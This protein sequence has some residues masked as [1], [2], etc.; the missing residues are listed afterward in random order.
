MPVRAATF[1]TYINAQEDPGLE[2]AFKRQATIATSSY[3][4][5]TRAAEQATRATANLLGG[6]GTTGA[7]AATTALTQR[8]AATRTMVTAAA[9]AERATTRLATAT[10]RQAS[11]TTT[12]ANR[13]RG[14]AASLTTTSTALNVVSGR[15]DPVSSRISTLARAVT[16]LTGLQ[17]GLAAF[18]ATVF[19][20]GR[21][22]STYANL[23]ARVR[24]FFDTQK[25][26]N[27]AMND[28]IGI[29]QRS[30]SALEPV[31]DVYTRLTTV[32]Q[33]I[34]LTRRSIGQ[35]TELATK[36]TAVGGG[37]S[38]ARDAALTQFGQAL[39]GDFKS[40]GQEINSLKEQAPVLFQAILKGY[41]DA[42]GT[43]GVSLG[44]FKQLAEAGKLS[45]EQ[46]LDALRRSASYIDQMAARVPNTLSKAGT[47]FSN[48]LT[49][50]V[51]RIDQ[52]IGFTSTLADGLTLVAQNLRVIIAL[53]GGA[54]T[55]F[56][57]IKLGGLV[58][59]GATA[60]QSFLA[61]RANAVA[62]AETR[63]VSAAA[64][65]AQHQREIA[66]LAAEQVQITEAIALERQRQ[67]LA[68]TDIRRA[69]F[70][71]VPGQVGPSRQQIA[72]E[73]ELGS[74]LKESAALRQRAT[75]ITEA[76]VA[77]NARA[78]AST[79][80]LARASSFAGKQ[81]GLLRGAAGGL[82]S[83]LG[84]PWGIAFALAATAVYLLA[85]AESAA[86]IATRKH[87]DAQ[88]SF[89]NVIDR[90]TGKIYDQVGALQRLAVQQKVTDSGRAS[91]AQFNSN[92]TTIG[93]TVARAANLSN[94]Q[95]NDRT[96]E[97]RRVAAAL[98]AFQRGEK[99]S[100]PALQGVLADQGVRRAVPGLAGATQDLGGLFDNL[101]KNIDDV[102]Q[103]AASRRV[104]QGRARDG[105][106]NRAFGEPVKTTGN[107]TKARSKSQ[108]D[109]DA[110]A[111]AA[112]T[113]VQRARAALAQT[114]ANGKNAGEDDAAY[115]H[116]LAAAYQAVTSAVSSQAAARKSASEG[117]T[118][119][120]KAA[121]DAV[122]DAKDEAL[123][124]RDAASEALL[125]SNP[126]TNSQAFLDARIKIL[127]TY[128]DE[129]NKIDASAAASHSASSQ[130]LADL[131]REEKAAPGRGE[132]R[133]DILGNYDEA[134][135]AIDKA[136]DQID[137][138][139]KNIGH[140][141][142]GIAEVSD[143]NP[144]GRGLYTKEI[145]DADAQRIQQGLRKPINDLFRDQE[146]AIAVATL[147]LQGRD[148]EAAALEKRNQLLD[149]GNELSNAEYQ[150]LIANERQQL[151]INDA[152][153][154]RQR[155]VSTITG[156]L[157]NARDTAE[158]LIVGLQ[159][160]ANPKNLFK[161]ALAD[162]RTQFAR[163][164]A[165][166]LVEKLFAGSDEKLRAMLSGKS[167]VDVAIDKF[168]SSV[169]NLTSGSSRGVSALEQFTAA[170][171][172]AAARLDGI[173]APG[174]LGIPSND[175]DAPA[176]GSESAEILVVGRKLAKGILDA[177]NIGG[178]PTATGGPFL[179]NLA[180][181]LPNAKQ[182]YNTVGSSFLAPVAKGLDGIVNKIT[183]K[184][185][186]NADGTV[187]GGSQFFRKIG[188]S[189]G[190]ALQGAGQG[191]FASS[192]AE[193]VGIKQSKTGAQVGGAI[194]GLTGIPGGGFIGGL[195][196]GT[197]GGL[198]KKTKQASST[199]GTDQ[200]GVLEGRSAVGT[201]SAAKAQA[202]ALGGSVASGL[203]S[204]AESLG[205]KIGDFGVSIG[206]RPG[207]KAGAYRV[208]TSGSGKLTGVQAFE[209]EEEAVNFAIQDAIKDGVL[210]GISAAS[211]KILASGQN[212]SRAL[213]KATAIE[214]IP[215]RLL[216]I[217]DPV[218][219]A[220]SELNDEFTNLISYLKEGGASAAQFADAQKLYDLEREAAIKQATNQAADAINS[221]LKDMVGGA[222][223]PL[224][225]RTT[226][227][228]AAS[229]LGKFKAD[230][231]SGKA[232]DQND[233][234]AAARNFQDASRAIYGSSQSF[235][236]D[237][238]SLRTLL[239][240]ARD[241]A[242]STDI[243]T[244]PASP[245]TQDNSVAS[246]I[247]GLSGGQRETTSA[248]QSGTDALVGKLNELIG[249]V[250]NGGGATESGRGYSAIDLLPAAAGR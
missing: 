132:K 222:S 232:V 44:K 212:L 109:A 233:L 104:I 65:L 225:K 210:K 41:K 48:S 145:A 63:K 177:P 106:L 149:G 234:L 184:G 17:L 39:S 153:A 133:R 174:G 131:E 185:I 116:R 43:I 112:Q 97:Q 152:L 160:G 173:Q 75:V 218:K 124:R 211:Q 231:A 93:T 34:G 229:E 98:A 119:E 15:L 72:A 244:L 23:E 147:Q 201:G 129:I 42:D 49:V 197:I 150:T 155:V 55:A 96:P 144:L 89:A 163:I 79:Q 12:A 13:Q 20:L 125:K 166:Q 29:A 246:T 60:A 52:T 135:K 161:S 32:G 138:L 247:A 175:N 199:I 207:H 77:A 86:E 227:D 205:A 128:D 19:A 187:V 158:Q 215:K 114:K 6:R 22:A 162:F 214:S 84:G 193:K 181:G 230:I 136:R 62:L 220:V 68:R 76:S 102:G 170:A 66:A 217:T 50:Q 11:E 186:T 224:N 204:I 140:L 200:Y 9:E 190:T 69:T 90:G 221:F 180:G 70:D 243:S 67:A 202:D 168:G 235:F 107:G 31:V 3:A 188:D 245:F 33:N 99:G 198:F 206:Y 47:D 74:S 208:D 120:R 45:T 169:D 216:Q 92:R 176:S 37:S 157:D 59:E 122:Q 154:A 191:A 239:T 100:L 123:A 240:K 189:F 14:F 248:V 172:G 95:E 223:S 236:N 249:A 81:V 2:A 237:F 148:V 226:Y 83:F 61:L 35:V 58:S 159:T 167:S 7:A 10:R 139:Q 171:T 134:P 25:S 91:I 108:I 196:G 238:E 250:N 195:I 117:R 85:T 165:R 113:E 164:N 28:I 56:A 54:I 88:R 183:G 111:E 127:Q 24:P 143:A 1:T 103:A 57:A 194:G 192:I 137:D 5:I 21:T 82:V 209:T 151:R 126:D 241:N 71:V 16:D 26:V 94:T 203:Q 141:V 18:G 78:A 242:G 182:V 27:T 115:Q 146:R 40:A 46:V 87:E 118:A 219:Y 51:G 130:R 8:T 4:T 64:S 142:D 156:A 101:R 80:S 228:N 179:P 38:Q 53:A 105:D 30:R 36:A 110:R 121:R 178:T 73:K 213:A